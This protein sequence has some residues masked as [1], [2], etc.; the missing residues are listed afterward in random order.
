VT[1]NGADC[2]EV[3]Y[4]SVFRASWRDRQTA[5]ARPGELIKN[6]R[7]LD[8]GLTTL[9][10]LLMGG[11]VALGTITVEQT[12]TMPAVVQGTSLTAD[13]AAGPPPPPAPGAAVQFRHSFGLPVDAVIVDVTAT[14]VTARLQE[15][16][17][18]SVG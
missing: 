10:L 17:P 5:G 13:R 4:Q 15:P 8:A 11:A 12:A 14:E 1:T 16:S 7:W 6:P 9:V 2:E 3:R 18:A